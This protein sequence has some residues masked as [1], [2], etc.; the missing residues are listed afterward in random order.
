M[1]TKTTISSS[2][3]LL[4]P[5]LPPQPREKGAEVGSTPNCLSISVAVWFALSHPESLAPSSLVPGVTAPYPGDDLFAL[6]SL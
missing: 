4:A 2:E 1:R 3:S 6:Y 5:P